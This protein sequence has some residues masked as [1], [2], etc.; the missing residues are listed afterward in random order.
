[1]ANLPY[2]ISIPLF[3]GFLQTP[4]IKYMTLMFQ[5]EVAD[6]IINKMRKKNIMGSLMA[7]SQNYYDISI[8]CEVAPSNFTPPPKVESTVL[9]LKRINNPVISLKNFSSFEKFLRSI[10]IYKRKQL[11]KVLKSYTTSE[12]IKSSLESLKIPFNIRGEALSLNEI[13]NL[14]LDLTRDENG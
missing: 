2:N 11:Q 5:R 12:K 10:F 1:M 3:I 13:Q 4:Q 14:Y 6:K 9:S 8:L 7:L